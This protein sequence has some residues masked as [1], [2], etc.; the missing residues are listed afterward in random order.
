M[1]GFRPAGWPD[2][3][4][5]PGSEDW[6]ETAVAFLFDCCP[7]DFRGYPVL[8][9][10]PVVLARFAARFIDAQSAAATEGL[11][12]IRVSLRREVPGEVIDAAAEAWQEQQATLARTARAVGLVEQAVR[13]RVFVPRL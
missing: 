9:R 11:A 7:P 4:R 13:G 1:N 5:P 12:E 2:S 3:V 6:L 8:R 10:H